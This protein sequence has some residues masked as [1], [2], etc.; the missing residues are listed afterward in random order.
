MLPLLLVVS[1]KLEI[2]D[3]LQS[4]CTP[5]SDN[6]YSYKN[7]GKAEILITGIGMTNMSLHLSRYLSEKQVKRAINIGFC[8]SFEEYLQLGDITEV[9]I[10]TFAEIGVAEENNRI[11]PFEYY[12]KNPYILESLYTEVKPL[13]QAV[14][15][16]SEFLAVRAVT[17]NSCTNNAQRAEMMKKQFKAQVESME[18]AAFFLTCNSYRIP[19]AQFRTVSN[20]IPGRTPDRWNIEKAL[21]STGELAEKLCQS[22]K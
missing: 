3:F 14:I 6:V 17:V 11:T 16:Q 1:T 21:K 7:E 5:F 2:K 20:H 19:C 22:G 13:E 15:L 10:D 9:T 8:G 18:G 4:F 12:F